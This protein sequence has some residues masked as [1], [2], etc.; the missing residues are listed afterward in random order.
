LTARRQ[1]PALSLSNRRAAP[2]WSVQRVV[3]CAGPCPWT[4]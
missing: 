2:C 3:A 4:L 1:H